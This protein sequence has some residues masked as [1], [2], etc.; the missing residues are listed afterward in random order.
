MRK[1]TRITH[2]GQERIQLDLPYNQQ[3]T[4]LLRQIT[5]ARW[6]K[7]HRAWHIPYTKEA[8][9]QLK[10]LFPD[11]ELA[12][13]DL[14]P[15]SV[16]ALIPLLPVATEDTLSGNA[17][18][19]NPV[20]GGQPSA[21]AKV[22]VEVIGRKII[23]RMPKNDLDVKFVLGLRYS[24]WDKTGRF[25]VIPDYPGNLELVLEYFRDRISQLI[26]HE[27]AEVAVGSAATR[28][29]SRNDVLAIKTRANR[30]KLVFGYNKSLTVAIK[31]MPF[32]SW[33]AKN[34]WWTI[35]FSDKLMAQLQ[36]VTRSEGLTL[37]YEEE[38][39][40]NKQPRKS[41]VGS[42]GHR[43]CPERYA[44]KLIELRY[45]PKTIRT[46]SSLLEEL[47]NYYPTCEIDRIDESM[48]I[49]FCRYLVTDR[50][51]SAS[52]QNLA[53]NAIKFYYERVLGGQ[54]RFYALERP[55]K[56]K[57]LP[58][59]LS[60]QEVTAILKATGNLK[61][62]AILTV[63]YSAGLRISELV[64]LKIK[65][66]DSNRMQIR[67][68]QSKGKKDRYTL[69]SVK[70]LILLRTYFK[71]YKPVEWLFTGVDGGA[72]STRSIQLVF[73]ESCRK[74]H[75]LKKV[76]VHTLRHSFAT[77]LLESGT[78]LRYIQSL[79]GHESSKTTEVYTHVTTKGFDQIKSPM[80][81]LDI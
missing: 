75:I 30:L 45:S 60:T 55:L 48:I 19:K 24:C 5:D 7:T 3:T 29:V 72:Y 15:V 1:I 42:V 77:H 14:Q 8:F 65:D 27:T 63:I 70:T 58:I 50:K 80:D 46:Y 28:K 56:E 22:Q 44:Q 81:A 34:K 62:R 68:A 79:L 9:V 52:Y 38:K 53:I 49:A 40:D 59:V 73:K 12:V 54:R 11:A 13:A 36:E 25:W 31:K 43:P 17:F 69:L 23:L 37:R 32:W 4:L 21:K 76:S 47:I 39:A 33:D 61:H 2:R 6:S 64:N 51:V 26:R 41:T 78:D 74:A 10:N 16:V 35:P 57:A 67:V 18:L 66:I 20:A 71:A